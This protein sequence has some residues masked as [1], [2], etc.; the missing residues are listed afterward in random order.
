MR[1][2]LPYI[3][4]GGTFTFDMQFEMWG[5]G[6]E[7]NAGVAVDL[8][9]QNGIHTVGIQGADIVDGVKTDENVEVGGDSD[10]GVV[11]GAT[12]ERFGGLL[13]FLQDHGGNLF[14]D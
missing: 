7:H 10:D 3:R 13:H 14:R 6:Y 8:A 5:Y 12:K 4:E 9:K 2:R 1:S 11:D